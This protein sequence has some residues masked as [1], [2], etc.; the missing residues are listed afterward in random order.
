MNCGILQLAPEDK[1]IVTCDLSA[2]FEP[3]AHES[4][5]DCQRVI[6]IAQFKY[7]L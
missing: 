4:V 1:E 7:V 5:A 2:S 6:I 3:D